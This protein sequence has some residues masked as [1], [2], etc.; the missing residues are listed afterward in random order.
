MQ[1]NL[2]FFKVG[3]IAL[4]FLLFGIALQQ[5]YTID[6]QDTEK[7][8]VFLTVEQQAEQTDMDKKQKKAKPCPPGPMCTSHVPGAGEKA[9]DQS[10]CTAGIGTV[11]NAPGNAC[12]TG[13]TGICQTTQMG[14]GLCKCQ[15]VMP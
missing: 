4:L 6:R 9:I 14:G 13:S 12:G 11:C 10:A 3:G 2:R 15:C 1:K 8:K 7:G 5:G